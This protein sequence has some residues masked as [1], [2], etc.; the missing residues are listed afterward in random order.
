MPISRE[1]IVGDEEPDH[2]FFQMRAQQPLDVV[3]G[4]VARL[5]PL[6]VDDRAEAALERAAAP[7]IER[8]DR[9]RV[10]LQP[11]RR[12]VGHGGALQPRQIGEEV[13]DRLAA[14]SANASCNSVVDMPLGLAGEERDAQIDR[15]LQVRGQS[16]KHREASADMEAADDDVDAARA[17][18][19]G[20]VHRARK[21]VALHAHQEDD[22]ASRRPQFVCATGPPR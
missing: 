8:P 21:L 6:H 19:A 16:V 15:L 12:Q 11:L 17:K 9:R 2:A 5:A 20:H 22:P 3:S 18:C 1:I 13:V 14:G 7:G 4:P 10:A